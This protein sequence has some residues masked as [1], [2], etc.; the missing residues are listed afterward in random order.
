MGTTALWIVAFLAILLLG[1]LVY[2]LLVT[3]EG[4]YLG[5]R[6]VA[7]LYDLVAHKYDRIK[8]F[9]PEEEAFLV[10]RPLLNGLANIQQPHILDIATGAGRVP[11]VI[12]P[13]VARLNG[14][15]IGLDAS[16]RMLAQAK[17]K[18]DSP[19]VAFV[20]GTAVALPFPPA[21][22]D[23]VVCLEALEFFP[24]DEAALREMARVLRPG[25]FLMLTRRAGWE[26]KAFLTR[27]R[28]EQALQEMLTTAG[29]NELG[30]H[31]WLQNYDLVTGR[32]A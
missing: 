26:G 17:A 13:A 27:Y 22:F 30:F 25:G 15:L 19:V 32:K 2:W 24:S 1:S 18:V 8:E 5:P 4:V 9:D 23:G 21:S 16:A 3:T 28:S 12:G 10:G 6:I 14:S 20:R 29:F 11:A 31:L 7:W